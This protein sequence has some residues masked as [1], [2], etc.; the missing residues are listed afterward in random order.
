VR[1][2]NVYYKP[3][4]ESKLPEVTVKIDRK[5]PVFTWEA[6]RQL[7]K[8][9]WYTLPEN[10]SYNTPAGPFR[11]EGATYEERDPATQEVK[12]R[13]DDASTPKIDYSHMSSESIEKIL[14]QRFDGLKPLLADPQMEIKCTRIGP[15]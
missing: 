3:S 9:T 7:L 1:R 8:P 13:H 15:P 14:K 2:L 10:E 12:F 4:E 11:E 6:M 5:P